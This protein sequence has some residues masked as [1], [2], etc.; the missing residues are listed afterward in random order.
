[1]TRTSGHILWA[2]VLG[3]TVCMSQPG[4]AHY[5]F[6]CSENEKK[7]AREIEAA[8]RNDQQ[9]INALVALL[10]DENPRVQTAVLLSLGNLSTSG[11]DMD[12]ALPVANRLTKGDE[13][14]SLAYLRAAAGA[15]LILLDKQLTR[16]QKQERLVALSTDHEGTSRRMAIEGLK[17]IGDKE[18]LPAL[19]KRI[20]DSFGDHDDSFDMK[21]V[22]RVAFEAWWAITRTDLTPEQQVPILLASLD[23]AQPFSS[24]W[25]DAACDVVEGMGHMAVPILIDTCR[26]ASGNAKAW[27]ARTLADAE[28]REEDVAQVRA[29]ALRDLC[30]DDEMACRMAP[31]LA[32]RCLGREDVGLLAGLLRDHSEP[33]IRNFAV[34]S[35]GRLGGQSAIQALRDALKDSNELTR[36][37]V[38]RALAALGKEDGH[39]VLLEALGSLEIGPRAVSLGAIEFLDRDRA[40]DRVLTLLRAREA[41]DIDPQAKALAAMAKADLLRELAKMPPDRLAPA[42]PALKAL[43]RHPEDSVSR[44]AADILKGIG[45]ALEWRHD[46]K[47]RRGWFEVV[48]DK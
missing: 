44:R 41:E 26:S 32:N 28:L 17:V 20:N 8:Q 7:R 47:Q 37:N 6:P 43:L 18:C 33:M 21:A 13:K 4:F 2:V 40:R 23:A 29:I 39:D 15:F 35:L 45:V 25:G 34:T 12:G 3:L 14:R 11:L 10:A 30:S 31:R 36:V 24:R 48:G 38:A 46:M 22:A 16:E 1:M 27:A 19:E 5:P 42:I 9:G